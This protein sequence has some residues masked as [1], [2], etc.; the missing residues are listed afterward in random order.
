MRKWQR[1]GGGWMVRFSFSSSSSSRGS[2]ERKNLIITTTTAT[3][4]PARG[5]TILSF[6]IHLYAN[7]QCN[8]SRIKL[9]HFKLLQCR[10]L[11]VTNGVIRRR[12]LWSFP[13]LTNSTGQG[14]EDLPQSVKNLFSLSNRRKE[15]EWEQR[16]CLIWLTVGTFFVN[17]NF[18][19]F[20]RGKIVEIGRVF[21]FLIPTA[22]VLSESIFSFN[23][24][25]EHYNKGLCFVYGY[26]TYRS[27]QL[28]AC[29]VQYNSACTLCRVIWRRVQQNST[30]KWMLAEGR[31]NI[32][33]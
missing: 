15:I 17:K 24:A 6:W 31:R 8:K 4:R 10:A 9:H 29:Y 32:I 23:S 20:Y 28:L 16:R 3:F 19:I 14:P 18:S 5:W 25:Y 30:K 21:I 13:R 7:L 11:G 12:R 22:E 27:R 2:S 33:Q 1:H 26:D